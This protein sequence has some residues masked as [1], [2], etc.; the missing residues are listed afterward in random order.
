[1]ICA[2]KP[3]EAT[4]SND[5]LLCLFKL[6]SY[7]G[8]PFFDFLEL[9]IDLLPD[10]RIVL[11]HFIQNVRSANPRSEAFH[12]AQLDAVTSGVPRI[13]K[14]IFDVQT[15]LGLGKFLTLWEPDR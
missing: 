14:G 6:L 10:P 12:F 1:M 7:R 8:Y 13:V 15:A 3:P 11:C 9:I 5:L 2:T 4:P